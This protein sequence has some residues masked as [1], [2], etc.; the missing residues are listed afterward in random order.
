V[1]G[2]HQRTAVGETV[3][4]LANSEACQRTEN[5]QA[6]GK[7]PSRTHVDYRFV[8]FG[9]MAPPEIRW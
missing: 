6:L 1:L 7:V 9:L 5:P 2:P 4:F 8:P 3:E